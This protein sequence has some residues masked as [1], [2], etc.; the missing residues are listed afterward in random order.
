ML[1]AL[2]PEAA[3]RPDPAPLLRYLAAVGLATEQRDGPDDG[4]PVL[5]CHELVRERIRARMDAHPDECAG[6]TENS[7]RLAYAER[8]VAAFKA[9]QHQN[10][11]AALEAG[12]RAVVYCVQAGAYERLG[13]FASGVVTSTGDPRLLEALLPHLQAAAE[14]RSGRACRVGRCLCYLA[15]ALRQVAA[16]MPACRSTS[17]PPLRPA[18]PPKPPL[19]TARTP[20]KPGRMS[21]GSPATGR[22][23]SEMLA[24][25]MPRASGS[26][27][28]PKPRKKRAAPLS[29]SSAANWKPCA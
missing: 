11:T 22:M 27:R 14:V 21:A 17:R 2:P 1:D 7:I 23:H 18:T 20:A 25:S 13:D 6:L 9:L 3:A 12:S 19:L 26:L 5:T 24:I 28:A 10:M 8:L 15:D 29:M 16:P 4:N